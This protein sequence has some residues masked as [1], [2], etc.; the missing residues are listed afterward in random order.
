M[1]CITIPFSKPDELIRNGVD[2]YEK[3]FFRGSVIAVGSAWIAYALGSPIGIVGG[4]TIGVIRSLV[5]ISFKA[6]TPFTKILRIALSFFASLFLSQSLLMAWKGISVGFAHLVQ[7]GVL[8]E[9][10]AMIGA[11]AF[12]ILFQG[13]TLCFILNA[14]PMRH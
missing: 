9:V 14:K 2:L 11:I 5:E 7:I 13:V 6:E 1:A 8:A 12:P 10:C 4:L 3:T